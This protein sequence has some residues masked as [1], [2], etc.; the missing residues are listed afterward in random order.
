MAQGCKEDSGA[1]SRPGNC[2][3]EG[4]VA[5]CKG[6]MA[7][8]E[9]YT[10]KYYYGNWSAAGL[11]EKKAECTRYGNK[12]NGPDSQSKSSAETEKTGIVNNC[13]V[14]YKGG[15]GNPQIDTLCQYAQQLQCTYEKTKMAQILT[16]KSTVCS[17][18]NATTQAAVT[19]KWRCPYCP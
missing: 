7:Y 5:N 1:Y 2:P 10:D 19:S 11:A 9:G 4:V 12:W 6:R 17:I 8:S 16:N 13:S 14:D 18:V 3:T 15:I